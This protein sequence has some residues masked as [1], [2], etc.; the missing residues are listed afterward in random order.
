MVALLRLPNY[1][2]SR[3]MQGEQTTL[4]EYVNDVRY[5]TYGHLQKSERP[6]ILPVCTLTRPLND[7]EYYKYWTGYQLLDIDFKNANAAKYAKQKLQLM[8]THYPWVHSIALS[9]SGRGLHIYTASST[10]HLAHTD[11][12]VWRTEFAKCFELKAVTVWKA[13]C[14]IHKYCDSLAE[15][16]RVQLHPVENTASRHDKNPDKANVIDTS[17]GKIS[18]PTLYTADASIWRNQAFAMSKIDNTIS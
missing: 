5:L 14:I 18:Q 3:K 1:L 16:D 9:S 4:D 12:S 2:S 15:E 10:L 7:T 17:M 13:L 6:I 11:A 8:L